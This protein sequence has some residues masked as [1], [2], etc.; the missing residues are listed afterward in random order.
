M[1]TDAW[2]IAKPSRGRYTADCL[3]W[4]RR[5][6]PQLKAGEILLRTIYLSLDPTS[7]NWLKLEPNS[8]YLPLDVGDVMIGQ[9]VAMVEDSAADGFEKGHLVAGLSGWE[10]YSVASAERVRKVKSGVP[11]ETNLS[12]FSHIGYAAA[13]GMIGIGNV[14]PGDTVVVSAAAGATGSLAAQIAKAK[15][16]QVVG[17]AGGAEKCRRLIEDFGLDAAIDYK[18]EDVNEALTRRCPKGVDLFF[19]NVGGAVLDAVLMH[20]AQ[21]ARIAI[22]GQIAL[23]DSTDEADGQGVRNL[24]QLVFRSARME[25]FL[26]GQLVD[27]MEE[28]DDELER[29]HTQ[30]RLIARAHVVKGLERAPEALNLIFT[31][32]NDGKLLIEVSSPHVQMS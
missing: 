17:I 31:G 7:R 9:T 25:G 27:R 2:V 32:R 8:T 28:F 20:L 11:L 15:G 14:Q 24:M 16:A 6:V 26:A 4:E 21:G 22:C 1:D 30:G 3:R 19:D 10:T 29:L 12:I 23:Y 5:V 13:T 18:S